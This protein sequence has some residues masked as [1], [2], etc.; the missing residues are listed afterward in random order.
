[1]YFLPQRRKGAKKDSLLTSNSLLLV[2]VSKKTIG[3]PYGLAT[4][5]LDDLVPL[6]LCGQFFFPGVFIR[7]SAPLRLNLTYV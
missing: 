5:I 4:R 6:R 2:W 1:M 7:S 3:N